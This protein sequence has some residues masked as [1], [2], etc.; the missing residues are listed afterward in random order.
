[1][2]VQ[3]YL[4]KSKKFLPVGLIRELPRFFANREHVDNGEMSSWYLLSAMGLYSLVPGTPDYLIGSPMFR[5]VNI[6]L[7][8]S[9]F[10]LI[11]AINNSPENYYVQS[12]SWNGNT[13]PALRI[14]YADLMKGGI[15]QFSMSSKPQSFPSAF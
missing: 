8:N 7:P 14:A 3:A 9:K 6:S 5:S 1:M 15:L 12:V 4:R 11:S 13:L 10:L 2:L